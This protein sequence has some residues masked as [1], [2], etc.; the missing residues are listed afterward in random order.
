MLIM[1]R[2]SKGPESFSWFDKQYF[3]FLKQPYLLKP[4]EQ[5][6]QC[7]V[8][9]RK[10]KR[11]QKSRIKVIP[12]TWLNRFTLKFDLTTHRS[13]HAEH[14]YYDKNFA[15]PK[16]FEDIYEQLLSDPYFQF[17]VTA[18]ILFNGSKIPT[19]FLCRIP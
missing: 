7:L 4:K 6:Y 3:I 15:K 18:V 19:S 17:L 14:F 5:S 8:V 2:C 1:I 9:S 11:R 16:G 10:K 12:P 13:C